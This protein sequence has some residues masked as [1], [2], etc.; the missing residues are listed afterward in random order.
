MYKRQSNSR[1]KR[2]RYKNF[3]NLNAGIVIFGLI[4]IYL[5]INIVIYFTTERT[6]YYEVTAGTNAEN[7]NNSYE[8]IALRDEIIK[9]ADESG[10]V[11]YFIREGS[12]ISKN[13]TL[14]SIDSSGQLNQLLLESGKESSKLTEDNLDTINTLLKD[15]NNNF[16][17]MNFRDLYDFKSTVKGTVV[18][19]MNMNSLQKLAKDKGENFVINKSEVS[20][21]VLYRVDD[22][23]TLKP[24]KIKMSDF[25]KSGYTSAHFSSG[26][27]IEKGS[28]IYKAI[29]DDEWSIVLKFNKSDVKKYKKT[30][31]ITIKFLKDNL[32][33]TANLKIVKGA[34]E[35]QYGVVTLAKYVV[36]YA[37]DRF[38]DIEIV[39]TPKNGL[40][41]PKS[42]V[43]TN[44]LYVIPKEYSKKGKDD[45]S[46]GFNIQNSDRNE[47]DSE[48]Y[49]PPI[50]YSDENNYYVS[51]SYFNEGD[52]I[53]KSDSHANYVIEKTQKFMGV[54][55]INNGYTVFEIIQIL[56]TIDEYY[57]IEKESSGLKI[58]DRIVLD[59]SKVSENQI[60]FQ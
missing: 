5:F 22:F 49:Y 59:A 28:P 6:K 11:D 36:R 23:E 41:I 16:D 50:A 46:I 31:N 52:V 34:D 44:E 56:D 25:D 57:I 40:K 38:L 27:K 30:S 55:N 15:F 13:T 60:I 26:D 35:N 54:Y 20:G 58:Y 21:I 43:V 42:S 3:F 24:R 9:Y 33:T 51:K 1:K 2:F 47:N 12:R 45:V 37:T 17:P 53:T 8:G 19:L 32:T 29:N 7:L 48:I 18:D 14:Y 10:Y 39:E 4:L